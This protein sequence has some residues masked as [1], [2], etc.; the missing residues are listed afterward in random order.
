MPSSPL[1][2]PVLDWYAGN[3]RDLPWR[4]P[5]HDAVGRAGQRGD[6]AAD[7]GRPGASRSTGRGWSAGR[8][9]AALAAEPAG[10]G[11]ARLGPARLPAAGA[12]AARAP[13]PRC[14]ARHDGEVPTSYADLRALPGVG[15]YTAAAVA[16]FALRRPARGARHQRPAG[17]GPGRRRRRA[18]GAGADR[19]GAGSAPRRCCRTSRAVAAR[20][21]VAVMELGALV[22]TARTPRCGGCPVAARCAWRLAG[23]PAY[24]GPA[25]RVQPFAGTDRQVRGLLMAVLREPGGT[26]GRRR[27]GRRLARRHPARPG[28]GRPPRRRPPRRGPPA[29]TASPTAPG[30]D[31]VKHRTDATTRVHA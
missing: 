14:V 3:A 19:G 27:A 11:G 5:G 24:D 7:A 25:R 15:D 8:R 9:P 2:A 23:A 1:H 30:V 31:H 4:A 26:G 16:S 10:R 28:P 20:W 21:A 17:A 22:C 6:A 29:P 18:A 13:R 12:A